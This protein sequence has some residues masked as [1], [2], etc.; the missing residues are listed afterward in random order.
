MNIK[1]KA[2]GFMKNINKHGLIFMGIV[3]VAF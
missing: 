3:Y 1:N 2:V